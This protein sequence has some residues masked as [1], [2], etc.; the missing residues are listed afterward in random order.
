MKL[1]AFD[2][3][4][5]LQPK[6]DVCVVCSKM[7]GRAR[8]QEDV[9]PFHVKGL[10]KRLCADCVDQIAWI[11]DVQC[12]HCGRAQR[13]PDCLIR[14][15][16]ALWMNRSAVVYQSAMKEWL[17][18]YKFQGDERLTPILGAMLMPAVERLSAQLIRKENL[19]DQWRR[20]KL[21]ALKWLQKTGSACWDGV[22]SV[23]VSETRYRERGFNQAEQLARIVSEKA[24]IPY[25]ELLV[26]S[27]HHVDARQSHQGRGARF[28]GLSSR[29]HVS[30][31][32]INTWL[33]LKHRNASLK[34]LLID[35]VYTTGN[36]IHAC[37][38][39]IAEVCPFPVTIASATWARS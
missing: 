35:D 3:M 5:W 4:Q 9:D 10:N 20:S 33:R 38:D 25:V 22:T 7:I 2:M 34:L 17:H 30:V 29:Y 26:R 18:R 16:S 8:I 36:T 13:C 27:T 28:Q 11:R 32:A 14:S 15:D 31:S 24:Q 1:K 37:A 39:A 6:R 12:M 23:P 21:P 19:E